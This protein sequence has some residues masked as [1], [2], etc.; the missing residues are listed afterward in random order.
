LDNPLIRRAIN[1]AIDKERL[2]LHVLKGGQPVATNAV[3]DLFEKSHGYKILRGETFDPQKAKELLAQAGYPRGIGLPPIEFIFNTGE[4]H[5]VIAEYVQRNLQENLGIRMIPRQHGV[6]YAAENAFGRA[7]CDRA[8]VM[9]WRLS[10]STDISRIFESSS[11]PKLFRISE[12][13]V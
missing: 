12:S 3:P 2:A 1:L 10:G 11:N 5:R 8:I 4:G 13:G 7:V 6:G 9:V